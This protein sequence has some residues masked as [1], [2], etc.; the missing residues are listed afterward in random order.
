[1]KKEIIELV[2]LSSNSIWENPR[3]NFSHPEM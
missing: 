3:P 2:N 1:M